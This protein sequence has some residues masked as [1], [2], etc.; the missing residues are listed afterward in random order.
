MTKGRLGRIL[1]LGEVAGEGA[2]ESGTHAP[3][4]SLDERGNI[5]LRALH[6]DR[7]FTSQERLDARHH[8]LDAMASDI[9]ARPQIPVHERERP[10]GLSV[11]VGSHPGPDPFAAQLPFNEAAFALDARD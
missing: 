4:P 8:L 3:M 2:S 6:G 5:Y 10:R 1:D 7:D 11:A 9:A